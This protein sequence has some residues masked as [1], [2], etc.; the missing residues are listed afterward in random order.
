MNYNFVNIIK[1][2]VLS[3]RLQNNSSRVQEYN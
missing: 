2:Q 3:T 1:Y